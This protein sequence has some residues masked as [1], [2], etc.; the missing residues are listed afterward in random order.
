MGARQY[1][2]K[3]LLGLVKL[4][5]SKPG[6]LGSTAWGRHPHNEL[7]EAQIGLATGEQVKCVLPCANGHAEGTTP[8]ASFL[9]VVINYGD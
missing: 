8:V 4:W 5:T 1:S 7:H 9:A 3:K 6:S 2:G